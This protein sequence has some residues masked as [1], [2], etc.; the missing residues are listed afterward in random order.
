[1]WYLIHWIVQRSIL[2]IICGIEIGG[3]KGRLEE[4]L[5]V[6]LVEDVIWDCAEH[7][8]QYGMHICLYIVG[9]NEE[10]VW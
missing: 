7:E 1:M 3:G 10:E 6:K 8:M 4:E 5:W 2:V 9:L